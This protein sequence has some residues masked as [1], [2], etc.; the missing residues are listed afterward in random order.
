MLRAAYFCLM[1]IVV[2]CIIA[3][4]MR[5]AAPKD[6]LAQPN[7]S[8]AAQGGLAGSEPAVLLPA[9]MVSLPSG[10]QTATIQGFWVR[11]GRLYFQLSDGPRA[12]LGAKVLV[13]ALDGSA[14]A[15]VPLPD[16]TA[17]VTVSDAGTLLVAELFGRRSRKVQ[18]VIREYSLDGQAS[19]GR[20][21]APTAR[22][23]VAAHGRIAVVTGDGRLDVHEERS[24]AKSSYALARP[25]PF[26][27]VVMTEPE[28][29]VVVDRAEGTLTTIDLGS[30]EQSS[31]M[32]DFPEVQ[33]LVKSYAEE[34]AMLEALL[35][36]TPKSSPGTGMVVLSTC[37]TQQG[38]LFLLLSKYRA[39]EGPIVLEV[40]MRGKVMRSFRLRPPSLAFHASFLGV[41]GDELFAVCPCRQVCAY[42][43]TR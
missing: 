4:S 17:S 26:A 41:E 11:K 10:Y 3:W 21:I 24:G 1:V 36:P 34:R 18:S 40:D 7:G 25:V 5:I 14:V 39:R 19:A 2:A 38:T 13:M 16:S 37:A 35:R 9:A 43:A 30:G 27:A 12:E 31:V 29:A 42:L 20:D 33:R 8:V 23:L 6:T 32:V 15:D 28:K 22:S